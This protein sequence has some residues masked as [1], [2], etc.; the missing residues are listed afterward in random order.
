MNEIEKIEAKL[1]DRWQVK[2]QFRGRCYGGI[3][4][5][6]AMIEGWLDA[7]ARNAAAAGVKPEEIE[8]PTVEAIQEQIGAE[9]A[10]TEERA[11]TTFKLCGGSAYLD[12]YNVKAMLREAAFALGIT[13]KKFAGGRGFRQHY[14][15]GVHVKPQEIM[16]GTIA[17]YEEFTGHIKGPKGQVAILR[18]M[19]YVEGVKFDFE[20]WSTATGILSHD[21]LGQMLAKAQEIGLGANRSREASKFDVLEFEQ[22]ATGKI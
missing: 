11:W 19:D 22:T 12:C 20:V 1:Y 17:G 21:M 10:E 14:Q 16:L 2:C 8:R 13:A 7:R 5:N 4:K 15:H 3:P 6:A 18:R 9:N